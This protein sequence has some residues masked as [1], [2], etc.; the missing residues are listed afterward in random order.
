MR[1][2]VSSVLLAAT[3]GVTLTSCASATPD[4][5][6]TVA[7]ETID[8]LAAFYPLEFAAQQVGG[9]SVTVESLTPRGAEPHDIELTP[10]QI[11][12]ISEADLILYVGG[13]QPAVDEAITQHGGDR[14]VDVSTGINLIPADHATQDHAEDESGEEAH[15][16]TDPH[17]WLDP[18]NMIT[19][20]NTIASRL[21]AVAGERGPEI[22]TR[23]Q[24]FNT[25]LEQLNER[26]AA[27]T[28]ECQNRNLVVSHEAF[29]YL[30]QRYD[31]DQLGISGL[32][33][34]A[35][36]SPAIVAKVTDFVKKN[37]VKTIYY[38]TLVDP[39]VAQ[40]V[41]SE[42][43]SKTAVLDPLEGLAPNSSGDY[44]TVM[45]NNLAAVVSGQPCS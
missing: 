33:P 4:E 8:V 24:R 32:S 22:V 3:L 39:K 19:I 27:G 18:E 16:G 30:A 34:E 31:F 17:I 1:N 45:N 7:T 11:V 41:A 35:E 36:P 21:G 44:F 6:T 20:S 15:D 38:E 14:S 42:T 10:Q 28:K 40:T 23:S 25:E 29:G 2:A 9:K 12:A 5:P 37:D 13:F 43:G 26:W